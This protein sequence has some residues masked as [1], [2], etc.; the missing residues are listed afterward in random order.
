VR[1]GNASFTCTLTVAETSAVH[2]FEH[3]IVK[4]S[5]RAGISDLSSEPPTGSLAPDQEFDAVQLVGSPVVVHV[6][7]VDHRATRGPAGDAVRV[8]PIALTGLTVTI[9]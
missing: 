8:T 6:S 1:S 9:I 4:I 5:V 3:V 7:V 2:N